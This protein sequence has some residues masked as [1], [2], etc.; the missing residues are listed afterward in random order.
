MSFNHTNTTSQ[1]LA[2]GT[3]VTTTTTESRHVGPATSPLSSRMTRQ[4]GASRTPTRIGNTS[5]FRP[6]REQKVSVLSSNAVSGGRGSLVSSGAYT[7]PILDGGKSTVP[8]NQ[9]KI[10]N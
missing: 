4:I 9:S 3:K 1:V 6:V 8:L 10:K 7:G 2:D 5:G